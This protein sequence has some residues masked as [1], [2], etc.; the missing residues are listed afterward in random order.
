MHDND[1][2]TEADSAPARTLVEGE[3]PDDSGFDRV[4][5]Q[6]SL[7]SSRGLAARR[8][9]MVLAGV[10]VVFVALSTLIAFKTPAYESADEPG[11]VENIE[12][13]VSGHWYG[14]ESSCQFT[15][16]KPLGLFDC[17]GDEAHQ[18]PLYYLA[19]AGWQR[20]VDLPARAP[21]KGQQVPA[22]STGPIHQQGVFLHHSSADQADHRFLLWLRIPNVLLGALTV[23][24]TFFAVRQV[25]TDPWTPV[26]GA[27][28]VAFL[29]RFVFLTSFVTNDNLVDL[30]G[31][32]LTFVAL[33]YAR[34]PGR[35]RI[36]VVG[37]VVGLLLMTKLSTLP[38]A[39]V[40]VPL[41]FMATG[42]K[43]RG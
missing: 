24:F 25:S 18:A 42:W 16:Q 11:H 9:K 39:I 14:M 13:L 35:G 20:L 37:A 28:F 19:F 34:S 27:S 15:V 23:L 10:I 12:T 7:D 29:P 4:P 8:A 36:A 33:R 17:Q 1:D 6:T 38:I 26:V 22:P 40:L 30:L 21:Y 32:V 31:A 41:A 2:R 3:Q 43:K 5:Q